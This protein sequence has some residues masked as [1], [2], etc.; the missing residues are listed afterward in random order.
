[1]NGD[2]RMHYAIESQILKNCHLSMKFSS[3]SLTY[4]Q[5]RKFT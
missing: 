2:W 1:M 5:R 3:L 4:M